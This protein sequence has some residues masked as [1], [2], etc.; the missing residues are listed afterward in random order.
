MATQLYKYTKK[1]GCIHL[2]KV[3]FMVCKFY[4][5]KAVCKM[6]FHM[7]SQ[8]FLKNLSSYLKKSY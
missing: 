5:N 3:K 8:K 6:S 4:F 2:K 7:Q 1:Q